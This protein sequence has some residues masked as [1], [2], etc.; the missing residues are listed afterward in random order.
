VVVE[1]LNKVPFYAPLYAATPVVALCHHLFGEVAFRQQSWPV[2]AAVWMAERPLPLVYRSVP[3]VAISESSRDDL[4][5]RGIRR[6]QVRVSHCGIDRSAV[7][8]EPIARRPD[9]V[10]YVG[11]LQRYK[12]VD[13]LLQAM[14]RLRDRFPKTEIVVVGEGGA[15]AELEALARSLGLAERVRFTGF[16]SDKERDAC[17]ASSRVCVFP[18]DKEGWGLTVI[19]ANALATPVVASDA[20][21]LRDSV[22][23]GETGFLAASRDVDAFAGSIGRILGDPGLAER[24]SG[25]ALAWSQRFDWDRAAEEM[26]QVVEGARGRP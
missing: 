20:P 16:V 19:E 6:S 8:F 9:R 10:V 25:S 5:R 24:L 7:P 13:V 18:S 11:R 21:G 17:L 26:A 3:F 14:A 23:H 12:N 1:C 4:V 2:A 15:R 22:R